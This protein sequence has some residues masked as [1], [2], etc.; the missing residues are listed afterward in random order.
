MFKRIKKL[1][2]SLLN[3]LFND[4]LLTTDVIYKKFESSNYDDSTGKNV[5]TYSEYLITTIRSNTALE[6]QGSSTVLSAIGFTAGE[7]FFFIR[8]EDIPRDNLYDS[9]ILK[10]YIVADNKEYIIKKCIPIF[11]IFCKV[12]V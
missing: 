11:D 6:A 9:T 7:M 1:T 8:A 2:K 3:K 10:D 12:Q 5:V 4:R